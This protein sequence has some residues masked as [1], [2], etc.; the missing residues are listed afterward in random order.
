MWLSCLSFWELQRCPFFFFISFRFMLNC[1]SLF[2]TI[3]QLLFFF[4][5]NIFFSFSLVTLKH[6][7]NVKLCSSSWPPIVLHI[8]SDHTAS[9]SGTLISILTSYPL[10]HATEL[11]CSKQKFPLP[12]AVYDHMITISSPIFPHHTPLGFGCMVKSLG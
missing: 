7:L 2:N 8:C 6:N 12:N 4:F 10:C 5:L 1:P 3:F 11:T 9:Q